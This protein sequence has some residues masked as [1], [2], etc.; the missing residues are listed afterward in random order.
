MSGPDDIK[1]QTPEREPPASGGRCQGRG[2]WACNNLGT[3]EPGDHQRVPS[4]PPGSAGTSG[5]WLRTPSGCP[6]LTPQPD[7][8]APGGA[9]DEGRTLQNRGYL[10]SGPERRGDGCRWGCGRARLQASGCVSQCAMSARTT[11]APRV[12]PSRAEPGHVSVRLRRSNYDTDLRHWV[13]QRLMAGSSSASA[14]DTPGAPA[15][16]TEARDPS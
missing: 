13:K 9:K 12:P 11:R 5:S 16:W 6:H 7:P 8:P 15:E 1:L 2:C 10:P 4:R 14:A 3:Q